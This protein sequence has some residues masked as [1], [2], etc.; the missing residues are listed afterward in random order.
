MEAMMSQMRCDPNPTSSF[1]SDRSSR[2]LHDVALSR[3]G[4]LSG[5]QIKVNSSCG[6]DK[7]AFTVH[8][9]LKEMKVSS[10]CSSNSHFY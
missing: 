8:F 10:W 1:M 3:V 9:P 5:T 6:S 4:S 7:S 2:G